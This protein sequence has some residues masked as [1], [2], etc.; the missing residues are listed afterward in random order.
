MIKHLALPTL[1]SPFAMAL[2]AA[3]SAA[4]CSDDPVSYSAPIGLNLKVKSADTMSGIVSDDKGITTESSNPYG[5]FISEARAKL[6]RDPG[7]IVVDE[8]RLFLGAS[9]TGVAALGEVFTGDVEVL[10]QMNDTNNSYPVAL[11]A[12]TATT[13]S[14]PIS[15]GVDFSSRDA[16]SVDLAKLVGGS[17]KVIVRGPAAA[18]FS[19]K[20]ADAD[21]Q[22][23]LTFS[24]FE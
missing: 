4:A 9:S 1:A 5:A 16:S 11:G 18:G 20:G 2:V 3:L 17:F 15:L 7:E 8:A 19:T 10:F 23:T 21:L 12:V 22:V 24:A 13:S 6:G 14:G